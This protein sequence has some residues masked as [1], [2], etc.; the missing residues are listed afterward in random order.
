MVPCRLAGLMMQAYL[1]NLVDVVVASMGS[2][3]CA[4]DAAVDAA[5]AALTSHILAP[6][7][8]VAVR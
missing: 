4:S 2:F 7:L 3:S 1:A 6:V 8:K 5:A